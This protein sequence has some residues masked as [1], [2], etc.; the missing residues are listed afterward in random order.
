MENNSDPDQMASSEVSWS[1]SSLL[2]IKG[3]LGLK[4]T[5]YEKYSR[6]LCVKQHGNSVLISNE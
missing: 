3:V 2:P 4:K 5:R 1:G 6:K